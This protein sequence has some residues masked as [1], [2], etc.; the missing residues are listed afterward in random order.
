MVSFE[1]II[2]REE[3]ISII[4]L[5]YV[6]ISLA[7]SFAQKVDVIGFDIDVNKINNYRNGIDLTKEVGNNALKNTTVFF[8]SDENKLRDAKFH[9]IAVP[10]PIY[11]NKL[12]NLKYIIEASKALGRNLSKDS[13]VVYESTVSRGY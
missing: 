5:G 6:G 3:K 12:P 8:T 2:S 9:I 10:T 11:P 7:I 13:I 4:G 1:E